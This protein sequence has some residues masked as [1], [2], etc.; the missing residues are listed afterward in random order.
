[1]YTHTAVVHTGVHVHAIHIHTQCTMHRR[2]QST[3]RTVHN[4][5]EV[6]LIPHCDDTRR[7]IPHYDARR[8]Q[9]RRSALRCAYQHINLTKT[10][11]NMTCIGQREVTAA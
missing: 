7:I 10:H 2:E 9:G 1:M 11:I 3:F 8:T 5:E 4:P 6:R